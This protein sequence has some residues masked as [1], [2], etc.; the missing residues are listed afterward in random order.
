LLTRNRLF[1]TYTEAGSVD[2]EPARQ[3]A[4]WDIR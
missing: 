2:G 4:S 3:S 1:G